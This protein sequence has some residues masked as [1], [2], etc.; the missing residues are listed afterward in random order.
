ML[1]NPHLGIEKWQFTQR[2]KV[3]YRSFLHSLI[4]NPCQEVLTPRFIKTNQIQDDE[5]VIVLPGSILHSCLFGK[6]AH[7]TKSRQ[8]K[9]YS[10]HSKKRFK[11]VR[12]LFE[13][14]AQRSDGSTCGHV[15]TDAYMM[16]THLGVHTQEK[17]F[18]C[19]YNQ[20]GKLF[21]LIGNVN[22]HISLSHGMKPHQIPA[23]VH[24][25]NKNNHPKPKLI[26]QINL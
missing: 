26:V 25:L 3:L 23:Y 21:N 15:S 14:T 20:C 13:C 11:S 10:F 7:S 9:M 2:D 5:K 17:R 24:E 16:F 6:K 12:K 4:T 8:F 18:R 1:N 19:T 22:R